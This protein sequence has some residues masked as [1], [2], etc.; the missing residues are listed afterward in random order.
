MKFKFQPK[1]EPKPKPSPNP[2]DERGKLEA[3]PFG[4]RIA[5]DG[6][7]FLEYGGR[8]VKTIKAS[9]STRLLQQLEG[10]SEI[11]VQ[12]ILAK[13]TGNFKRGNEKKRNP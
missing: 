13:L 9:E 8:V 2:I 11:Q 1:S 5:K 6:T 12:L 3:E 4:Y 7:V 10:A